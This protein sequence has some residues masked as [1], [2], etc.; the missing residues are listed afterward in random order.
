MNLAFDPSS[1]RQPEDLGRIG[2]SPRTVCCGPGINN[3]DFA[4]MKNAAIRENMSLQFRVELFNV[5][6]H[7]Q[8]TK[9]DGNISDGDPAAGG[10]FGMVQRARDPRLAQLALKILF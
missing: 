7:A 4:L 10:T 6:N 1:F 3:L 2:T 8:F 9:V 5:A